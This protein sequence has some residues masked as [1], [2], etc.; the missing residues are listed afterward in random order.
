MIRINLLGQARPK[1]AKQAV[2]LEATVQILFACVAIGLAVVILGISYYQEKRQLDE[3][4]KRIAALK[5][6]KASL[7]QIKADVDK[8]ESEKSVLQQRI[9]V[10][11]TLQ[12]N[13]SGAQD[14]MEMVANTVVRV[15]SLWL[16]SLDRKGDALELQGEA[17]SITAVANFITELKKSGYFQQ[18]EI[19]NAKENDLLPGVETYGFDMTVSV[20]PPAS[21]QPA[22]QPVGAAQSPQPAAKGRS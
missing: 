11:E 20:T 13:R 16:T 3:T 2:P 1:A 9:D 4:E 12:K 21:G 18:V 19:K 8:F 10:I 14:M 6:E 7:Q 5:A 17:G 22:T 15:D